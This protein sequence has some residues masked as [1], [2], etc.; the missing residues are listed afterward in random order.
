MPSSSRPTIGPSSSALAAAAAVDGLARH[1]AAHHHGRGGLLQLVVNRGCWRWNAQ[2]EWPLLLLE[3]EGAAAAGTHADQGLQHI[4][5][6]LDL[7]A[8]RLSAMGSASENEAA[9]EG[10]SAARM[11]RQARDMLC[12]NGHT[13]NTRAFFAVDAMPQELRN[14]VLILVGP[15]FRSRGGICCAETYEQLL[16][17]RNE[18]MQQQPQPATTATTTTTT[19]RPHPPPVGPSS[20]AASGGGAVQLLLDHVVR[21]LAFFEVCPARNQNI[22]PRRPFCLL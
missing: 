5:H 10:H 6:A 18:L 15:G 22:W 1:E 13:A 9:I 3:G 4:A 12:R 16:R 7:I 17:L 20:T 14:R 21:T 8:S 2:P 19:G 11:V